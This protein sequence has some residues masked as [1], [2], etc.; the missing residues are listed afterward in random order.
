MSHR[1][2]AGFKNTNH[3][4]RRKRRK[5]NHV[6]IP[7]RK[8]IACLCQNRNQIPESLW[9]YIQ[10]II[11]HTNDGSKSELTDIIAAKLA[12]VVE[13]DTGIKQFIVLDDDSHNRLFADACSFIQNYYR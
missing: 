10:T 5:N 3:G 13:F 6:K 12:G 4:H 9:R 8:A 1:Y 2:P 7:V 11:D